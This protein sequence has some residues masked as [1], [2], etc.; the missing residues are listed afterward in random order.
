M[1][2]FIIALIVAPLV[3]GDIWEDAG[4]VPDLLSQ[5]PYKGMTVRWTESGL[6]LR[7]NQ[8]V[9]SGDIQTRPQLS[10]R[11]YKY[12]L[13]TIMIVDFGAEED[14]ASVVHWM[15]TNVPGNGRIEDGDEKV[16]YLPPFSFAVN[17]DGTAMAQTAS[18]CTQ[19]DI[20]GRRIN[21]AD[22]VTSYG[23]EGPAAGNLFWTKYS[24]AT[25]DLLCLSS[26]CVGFPF[27][28]PIEGL[29][30]LPEC[31]A[32]AQTSLTPIDITAQ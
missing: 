4:I 20:F 27:P 26:S 5:S 8:T 14:G 17:E 6:R 29:T 19:E 22:F 18:G 24:E 30:D 10:F 21:I 25:D 11:K 28:F 12:N 7:A 31:Q 13:Y 16:E 23:L 1:G 2:K 3:F 9:D 15:V 32:G